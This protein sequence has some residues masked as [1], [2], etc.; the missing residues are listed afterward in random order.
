MNLNDYKIKFKK[1]LAKGIE[2]TIR[3][4]EEEINIES[5]LFDDF[6]MLQ[7]QHNDAIKKHN[8]NIVSNSELDVTFNRIRLSLINFINRLEEKDI[9]KLNSTNSIKKDHN[10]ECLNKINSIIDGMTVYNDYGTHIQEYKYRRT[11]LI[12]DRLVFCRN[13]RD[14][15]RK[16]SYDEMIIVNLTKF[17]KINS[18]Y[19]IMKSKVTTSVILN[20]ISGDNSS[21]YSICPFKVIENPKF[22][23]QKIEDFEID[24]LKIRIAFG[25][26][27]IPINTNEQAELLVE[28]VKTISNNLGL[29][30]NEKT[31]TNKAYNDQSG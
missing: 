21:N 20:L 14:T 11:K 3:G 16:V 18:Y 15:S 5:N 30:F 25:N 27:F 2:L 9:Y 12:Y 1:N 13:F 24:E 26:V 8:L 7:S 29:E 19:V 6:V 10:N 23:L 4:L 17:S 22:D 28:N 31:T